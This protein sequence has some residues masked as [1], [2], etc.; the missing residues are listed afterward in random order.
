MALSRKVLAFGQFPNSK[1]D[2]YVPSGANGL[3]HNLLLHNIGGAAEVVELFYHD[4]ANE[5]RLWRLTLASNETVVLDFRGEGDVVVDGGKITGN[6][7]TA[8]T[9]TYKL[10][11][12]EETP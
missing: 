10:S 12:T 5:Y 4:G 2:L 6:S 11:G 1:G 3:L 7:T 8:A 9:V